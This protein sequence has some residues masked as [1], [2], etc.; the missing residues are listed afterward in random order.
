MFTINI[1]LRFALI[2]LC[3]LGGIGMSA[4]LGFWYG[5]PFI[6]VGIVLLVGYIL[7]GTVQSGAMLMQTQNFED[8]E[9]RLDLTFFPQWLFKPNR[10]Y[11]YMIKGMIALQRKDNDNGE[12]LLLKAES[13]GLPGDN[14]KAMIA[15]NIANIHITKNNWNKAAAAFKKTEGLKVTEPMLKDQLKMFEKALSQKGNVKV[16]QQQQMMQGGFRPG[17]KRPRPKMR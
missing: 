1:Y 4:G 9:K 2:A 8:A 14:E 13:I 10:A 3:I 5:F 15:M 7:L 11:F 6:L 17:G 12:R 16:A